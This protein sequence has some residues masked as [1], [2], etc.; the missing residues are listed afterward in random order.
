MKTGLLLITVSLLLLAT[1]SAAQE[2]KGVC[3]EDAARFCADIAPG[4]GRIFS[5]L[6]GRLPELSPACR[7][8]VEKI[9][10]RARKVFKSCSDDVARFCSNVRPERGAILRCLRQNRD[11]LS[12]EC[13]TSI[14][15]GTAARPGQQ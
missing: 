5:C 2:N 8:R 7:D 3:R 13:R 6:A 12:Q 11:V 10:R 4:D 15:G 1:A 9:Q 14:Y